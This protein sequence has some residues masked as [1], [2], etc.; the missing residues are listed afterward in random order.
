MC[1]PHAKDRLELGN[2]SEEFTYLQELVEALK[3]KKKGWVGKE[4]KFFLGSSK[5]V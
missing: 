4:A 5:D 1:F 3:K 2:K